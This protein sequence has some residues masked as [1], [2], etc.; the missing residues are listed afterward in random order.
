MKLKKMSGMI[1]KVLSVMLLIGVLV[2]TIAGLTPV[3]DALPYAKRSIYVVMEDGTRLAVRYTL[4]NNVTG[5]EKVPAIM[6]TTRYVTEYK[7]TFLLNALVN[8]KIARLAP[9][10]TK[11]TF[12]MA[13][14]AVVE[15]D[16]RG[17]GASEGSREMEF[18]SEEIND[19]GQ[20]VKWITKQ[21]W[22]DG[23]VAAYG[24]SYSG[25]TA[26]LAAVSDPSG[27][28]AAAPLYPDFDVMGQSAFPGGIFNEYLCREW[29][30]ANAAMDSNKVKG[31]FGGG[32]APVDG[33]KGEKLLKRAIEGHKTIDMY[34]A[35]S[36][37]TYFDD[38][39]SSK[40]KA[41]S[42]SPF[43]YKEEIEKS[44]IPLFVRV[45]WQDAATVNGA[46]ERFLTYKNKQVLVIG[47]WS[48]GGYY[49]CDPLLQRRV[50]RKELEET[51]AAD[52]VAFLNEC[53][54]GS[55]ENEKEAS[56][57]IRYYTLGEGK[58]KTTD[59]W[60]VEGFENKTMY[61]GKAGSL[62]DIKPEETSGEDSYKIDY[63][64]TT[65]E[66]NRWRTNLGGGPI[67]YPDRAEED[68]K[69]L[70][71]TSAALEYPVEITGV[72][73]VTLNLSSSAE[74]GAFYVYL[75][76][77]APDGKVTYITEGELRAIHRKVTEEDQGREVLGPV[78]SYLEKDGE[79]L[80][81]GENSE[82]KIG[83]LATSVLIPEGHKIRIAIAGHDGS[84]F[85]KIAEADEPVI[86]LQRN[87]SL[88]SYVEL[89]MKVRK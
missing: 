40:Y 75:E 81:P 42:M 83:M 28:I 63:T 36:R 21:E 13:G 79:L 59:K 20:L 80:V 85:S 58:W 4:P 48:H 82:L 23:R 1:L 67:V 31:L 50:S 15:A 61:F 14:Y 34:K 52:V 38:D 45:G 68:K 3:K 71:Y 51:Q 60:P 8:L 56:S 32:I 17:S 84:N 72:P 10:T 6:E 47:P 87:S 73:V 7:K 35:L 9:E 55:S 12:L 86:K 33:D 18:S 74:D 16:V 65:G 39:L 41:N 25:N 49:F 30:K 19:I 57:L 69:L 77:V 54:K 24:I 22:S 70:T 11:T 44:G 62:Q 89:P 29:N 76:D 2:F 78:H 27:L 66:S 64:T 88:S 53:L 43:S 37:V 26:E 46:I 5:G